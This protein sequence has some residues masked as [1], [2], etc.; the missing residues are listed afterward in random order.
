MLRF[1]NV[2]TLQF[3]STQKY[4]IF[5]KMGVI[6]T[7]KKEDERHVLIHTEHFK[8][9]PEYIRRQLIF[10][11]GYGVPFNTKVAEIIRQDSFTLSKTN[12]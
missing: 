11:K 6:G 7:S 9:L 4:M 10:E 12:R 3:V 5:F 1:A 2:I 8:R